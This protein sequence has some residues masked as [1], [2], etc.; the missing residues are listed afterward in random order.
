MPA[1]R[2]KTRPIINWATTAESLKAEI[3]RYGLSESSRRAL[4]HEAGVKR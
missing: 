1:E 4:L 3:D 2:R